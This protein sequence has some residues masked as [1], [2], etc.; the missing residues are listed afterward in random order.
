MAKLLLLLRAIGDFEIMEYGMSWSG[1]WHQNRES[2]L[3]RANA[4]D[5]QDRSGRRII[6]PDLDVGRALHL[7]ALLWC[8]ARYGAAPTALSY[9]VHCDREKTTSLGLVATV[10]IF[11]LGICCSDLH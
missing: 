9:A 5:L 8:L 11:N 4:T 6:A 2:M 1:K 7:D 3:R 10:P